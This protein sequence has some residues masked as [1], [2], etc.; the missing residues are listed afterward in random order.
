MARALADHV[1]ERVVEELSLSLPTH[2]RNCLAAGARLVCGDAQ[3]TKSRHGF[4]F[5][6]ELQ[7]RDGL[8]LDRLPDEA[9]RLVAE[10]HLPRLGRLLQAGGDVDRVA[11]RQPLFRS[12]HH[13]AG[14]DSGPQLQARAVGLCELGVQPGERIA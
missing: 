10:Q 4:G 13:F 9:E 5:A 8:D 1:R 14:V 3:K 2:H 6:L 12:G 11:C 7:R